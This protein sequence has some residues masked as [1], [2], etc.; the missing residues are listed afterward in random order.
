MRLV[1]DENVEAKVLPIESKLSFLKYDE[2]YN[3]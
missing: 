3:N 1:Q 2:L